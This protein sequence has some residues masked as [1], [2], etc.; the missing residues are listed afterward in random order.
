MPTTIICHGCQAVGAVNRVTAGLRCSCGS[1]DLDLYSPPAPRLD[2]FASFM[3]VTANSGGTGWDKSMPDPLDGWSAYAGPMPS[4]TDESNHEPQTMRCPVCHGSGEDIRDNRNNGK[5]REC[6][7]TGTYTPVTT[8]QEPHVK[9][10]NYPSTQTTRP[11]IGHRRKRAGRTSADPM[12]SVQDHL[13]STTPGYG[14]HG[15]QVPSKEFSWEDADTHYPR[16]PNVSPNVKTR[17][18]HDYAYTPDRPLA[19]P[20]APCPVCG[21]GQTQLKL[22]RHDD[23]WWHC[24]SCKTPLANVDKPGGVNPFQPPKDFTPEKGFKTTSRCQVQKTGRVA[25]MYA[26]VREHNP[27]L[28]TREALTIVLRTVQKFPR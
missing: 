19:L 10:H 27:G 8:P 5:C 23:A 22:D 26:Q 18:E 6:G 12:G 13:K 16:F 14:D 7:G 2:S 15:W 17:P 4:V 28:D 1:T 24:P 11:F 3:G 9:R 21:H 20:T 25:A